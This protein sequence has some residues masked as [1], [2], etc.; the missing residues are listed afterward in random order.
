MSGR[1]RSALGP[2]VVA[3]TLARTGDAGAGV[4]I[5]LLVVER[6]GA[7]GAFTAGFLTA[8]LTA[9]HLLGQWTGRLVDRVDDARRPLAAACAL[10]GIA[11]ALAVLLLSRGW[12]WP[13]AGL[14]VLAGACGPLLTGG[15]S[16]LVGRLGAATARGHGLDAATYGLAGSAG[17]AVV[18]A[19]A[20]LT[21]PAAS[22]WTICLL[23]LAA[24]GLVLRVPQPARGDGPTEP[25]TQAS[26]PHRPT[27]PV[28]TGAGALLLT[29]RPL[30]R[31]TVTTLTTALTGGGLG[32]LS[33]LLAVELTGR[34]DLG[35]W[36]M[37]ASGLG[38]LAGSLVVVM[39][40]LRGEPVRT[41]LM[42]AAAIGIATLVIAIAPGYPLALTAFALFGLL[43][44]PWVTATLTARERYA[45]PGRRGQVF[46]ALAG[47][48]VAAS[49]AGGA[50]AGIASGLGPRTVLA[51]GATLTLTGVLAETLDR[52]RS[53]TARRG[54]Q[55]DGEQIEG[56]GDAHVRR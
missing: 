12:W 45:P 29:S 40:P 52:G 13:A 19:L 15:L 8:A 11:L 20:V 35:A 50:L 36:L 23:V 14:L 38:T 42:L 56:C 48:K 37:T 41:S 30:R 55:L 32:V 25:A 28:P 7:R 5:V 6:L 33:V 22:L 51:L 21:S 47:W 39:F 26:R 16:S 10:Y 34:G 3:A 2:Y 44:A 31:L 43:T 1:T 24:A 53:P 49:S 27:L 46:V 18:A 17:P 9:P 54:D 4:G